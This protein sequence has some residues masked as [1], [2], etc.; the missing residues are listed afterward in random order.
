MVP[1]DKDVKSLSAQCT[2]TQDSCNGA[3]PCQSIATGVVPGWNGPDRAI[4]IYR[5]WE[6]VH[7]DNDQ[8]L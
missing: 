3:T 2:T 4:P 6:Q 1:A 7:F 8:L 5:R